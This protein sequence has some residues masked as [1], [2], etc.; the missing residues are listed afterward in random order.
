MNTHKSLI[1]YY[2]G[3]CPLCRREIAFYRKRRGAERID[4][5]DVSEAAG[6]DIAPGLSTCDA[7][8]RFHVRDSDG[9][10][11]SGGDAFARL[12]RV[13]PA[14]RLAGWLARYQPFRWGLNRSYDAF[15][16]IRPR[17]QAFARR[18]TDA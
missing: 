13:L 14:F 17:L 9:A 6:G 7:R 1:V 2:D 4:W 18:R 12:W 15:L 5:R 16:K 10:L 11:Y 8:A 3:A